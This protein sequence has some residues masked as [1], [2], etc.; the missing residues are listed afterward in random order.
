[1]HCSLIILIFQFSA[2]GPLIFQS[3]TVFIAQSTKVFKP[4]SLK[5][6]KVSC[7]NSPL[8]WYKLLMVWGGCVTKEQVDRNGI[9]KLYYT[10][11]ININQNQGLRRTNA[12]S[13]IWLK[14]HEVILFIGLHHTA[15]SGC[16]WN[17]GLRAEGYPDSQGA[18]LS[19]MNCYLRKCPIS[20]LIVRLFGCIYTIKNSSFKIKLT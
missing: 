11:L 13:R 4:S 18:R 15:C 17:S 3:S 6:S 5:Y 8:Y 10:V 2:I 7:R 1:M 9:F 19:S 20:L 16:L 14:I 12:Q